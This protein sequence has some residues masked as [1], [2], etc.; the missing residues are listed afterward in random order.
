MNDRYLTHFDLAGFT[1]Y[2]GVEVFQKLSIGKTLELVAEPENKYDPNA[3]AIY[4]M[5]KKLGYVPRT[6]NQIISQ[7]LNLGYTEILEARVNRVSPE[8]YPEKQV[9]VVVL[10]KEKVEKG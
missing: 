9:G 4:F 2:D 8:K 10:F 1:Y 7:L 5:K 3:I 6:E